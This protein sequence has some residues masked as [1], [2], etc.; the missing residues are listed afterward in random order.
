MATITIYPRRGRRLMRYNGGMTE[1]FGWEVIG[2]GEPYRIWI[3]KDVHWRKAKKLLRR[4]HVRRQWERFHAGEI[5]HPP[6]GRHC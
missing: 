3:D 1:P 5:P 4:T 6:K 2:P